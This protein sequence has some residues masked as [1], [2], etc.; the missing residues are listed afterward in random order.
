MQALHERLVIAAGVGEKDAGGAVIGCRLGNGCFVHGFISASRHDVGL[1]LSVS[2]SDC[3]GWSS[4]GWSTLSSSRSALRLGRV[5]FAGAGFGA[6]DGAAFQFG[7]HA[8]GGEG[9]VAFL[10]V[11]EGEAKVEIEP[12]QGGGEAGFPGAADEPAAAGVEVGIGVGVLDGEG[13]LADAAHALHRGEHAEAAESGGFVQALHLRLAADEAGIVRGRDCRG[14]RRCGGA[15]RAGCAAIARGRRAGCGHRPA[16]GP[17]R[18]RHT[19]AEVQMVAAAHP[20]DPGG[21]PLLEARRRP[22]PGSRRNRPA[23]RPGPPTARECS[24]LRNSTISHSQ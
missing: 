13:G 20:R 18:P 14:H 19:R 11:V 6:L 8:A 5:I 4:A 2:R 15:G 1:A 22:D 9:V 10:G 7:K 23:P 17:P 24:Y 16:S 12:A 3:G 21:G